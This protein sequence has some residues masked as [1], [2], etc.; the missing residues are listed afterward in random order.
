MGQSLGE[1]KLGLERVWLKKMIEAD[2]GGLYKIKKYLWL[3]S[4]RENMKKMRGC[5]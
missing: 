3:E 1:N 5:S 2:T 4:E